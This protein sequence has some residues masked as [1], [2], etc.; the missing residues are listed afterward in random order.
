MLHK[1]AVVQVPAVVLIREGLV[2]P[3]DRRI[4]G[5]L[6]ATPVGCQPSAMLF[7]D[8]TPFLLCFTYDKLFLL[9]AVC[10]RYHAG[11][12]STGGRSPADSLGPHDLWEPTATASTNFAIALV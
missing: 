9:A 2:V 8:K 11:L 1:A 12:G 5:V 3:P 7:T 4:V 10:P 6:A